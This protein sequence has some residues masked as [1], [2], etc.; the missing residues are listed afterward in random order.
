VLLLLGVGFLGGLI[1]A[2]SP[3]IIPV[4]PVIAAG[5]STGGGP[6]RPFAIIGGMVASFTAFTLAGGELLGL[7]HLPQDLLRDLGIAMLF[8]L[9]AGLIVP[10]LG[11]LLERPFSRLGAGNP[12]GFAGGTANGALLGVSL[13]LVFVPCAGP[14]LAAI[15]AVAATHR[16]GLTAVLLTLSYS[17]GAALP[18]LL[19]AIVARRTTTGWK[20]LRSRMPIVRR[21]AGVVLALTAL[22]LA[23]DLTTPLTAVPG[24]A[25]SIED[26]IEQAPGVQGQLRALQGEHG[27]NFAAGQTASA[28][29]LPDLGAAPAFTGIT[30]WLNTPGDRPLS[31]AGLRGKVVLVDFWTYSCINCQRELPH[32]EAWYAE[33]HRYGLEV[34]GVHTPEFP[35]EHV[36]S[37]VQAAVGR[38][39]V[40]FPVAVDD[41]YGTWNAYGNEYWPADYL[42]DQ[43]GNVRRTA[44]G[45][46]QYPT[47][48]SA[49]RLL[50]EAGG[51]HHLPPPTDLADRT[52]DQELTTETYLGSSRFDGERY[53]GSAVLQNRASPYHLMAD[54]PSGDFSLGGTWTQN[55]WEITAGRGA[56][57][58]LSYM[59]DDVY[60]VLGG[61]GSVS[62]SVNGVH[63]KTVQVAGVPDLYT[64]VSSAS[65]H[66]ALLTLAMSPGVQAYDFT[67]G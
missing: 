11:E 8:L 52:P 10:A 26:H 65:F 20:A 67:F 51:A 54:L 18:L 12:G 25:S 30:R 3:C 42:I 53:L 16:V 46:G 31:L 62:V 19:L 64:L 17:L 48:E 32:V 5:G 57:L 34:V 27:R 61:T 63:T 13:G 15:S 2:L 7:L 40:R 45:E 39:G 33:Y 36:V 41:N 55:A 49:I 58:S 59:A 14:V 9:A 47:T 56:Q 60:L 6:A 43:N 23:L 4:L 22:V 24:Y 44:F 28:G 66:T 29:A 21:V 1:T 35:F 50:L 38:L 37:N